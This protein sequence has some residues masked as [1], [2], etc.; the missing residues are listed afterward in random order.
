VLLKA[1]AGGGGKGMRNIENDDEL[2]RYFD[3][4]RNEARS[5]FGDDEV[6]IE[7]YLVDPKHIEIQLFGD[8]HGNIIHLFERD[9][10][11]QRRHQKV[12]EEAPC[13]NIRPETRDE[14]AAAALRLAHEV[15][16]YSSGT[17][18]FLMDLDQNFYFL[19]MNTR[20]QVEH[21]VTECITGTDLVEWQIRVAEG[22]P[23]LMT[24]DELS[25][26]GHAI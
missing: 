19:E 15:G 25:I 1:A 9:C 2:L 18:E 17:V 4:G 23:L 21:P 3:Q 26:E 22:Q 12:I 11:I 10:S 6:F 24:Q 7:K 8:Q 14:M 13:A 5:A 20:L 16:Y